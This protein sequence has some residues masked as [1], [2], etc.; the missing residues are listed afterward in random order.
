MNPQSSDELYEARK[1]EQ[2]EEK[3][4][5]YGTETNRFAE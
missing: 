3:E 1:V 5:E 4:Q 2:L